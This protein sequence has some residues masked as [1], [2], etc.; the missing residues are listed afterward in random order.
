M[1]GAPIQLY[2]E[3]KTEGAAPA[4][5]ATGRTLS[6]GGRETSTATTD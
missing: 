1:P 4:P 2:D 6:I 5:S 3:A